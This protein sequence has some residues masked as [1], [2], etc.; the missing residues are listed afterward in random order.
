MSLSATE[1]DLEDLLS[2]PIAVLLMRRDGVTEEEVRALADAARQR[3]RAY[4]H[5][6][7]RE[8]AEP[9]QARA[10]LSRLLGLPDIALAHSS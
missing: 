5:P 4:Q 1:R 8:P 6:N 3:M 10:T 7:P 9:T 2:D